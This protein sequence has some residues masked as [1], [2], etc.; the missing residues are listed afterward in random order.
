MSDPFLVYAHYLMPPLPRA[1]DLCAGVPQQLLDAKVWLDARGV[2]G[3]TP[4]QL[5]DCLVCLVLSMVYLTI[6]WPVS[7]YAWRLVSKRFAAV[8]AERQWYVVANMSKALCLAALFVSPSWIDIQFVGQWQNV[9][10]STPLYLFEIKRTVVLY[11]VT[12]VVALYMVPKL[13]TST[14]VHHWVALILCCGIFAFDVA[15]G[16]VVRKIGLYGGF[17]VV[18]YGVNAYLA[19]RVVYQNKWVDGMA[20]VALV[21]YVLSCFFNWLWHACWLVDNIMKGTSTLAMWLYAAAMVVVGN[22]D[23]V[24]MKWL[25]R[26]G[27][28]GLVAK[29]KKAK[30]K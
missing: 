2:P 19:L 30:K 28:P 10:D 22:D 20:T 29:D 4:C 3:F 12:D 6:L 23:V 7:L 14:I 1:D 17:S 9:W 15:T 25:W 27:S 21:L 16:D 26:R 8:P 18:A 11:L 5:W 24:L 13:P